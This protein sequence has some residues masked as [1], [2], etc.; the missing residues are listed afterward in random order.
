[1]FKAK[2]KDSIL[3]CDTDDKFYYCDMKD[4]NKS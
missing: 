2:E 3:L 4:L 1:M